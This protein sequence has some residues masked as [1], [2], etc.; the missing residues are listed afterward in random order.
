LSFTK[1]ELDG[2]CS[3]KHNK[4]VPK[5]FKIELFF[6]PTEEIKKP[7]VVEDL[8][9]S[10]NTITDLPTVPL[11]ATNN[12]NNNN[13]NNSNS[14][15]KKPAVSPETVLTPRTLARSVGHMASQPSTVAD[16][17]EEVVQVAKKKYEN[18]E[19]VV[20]GNYDNSSDVDDD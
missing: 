15:N 18:A 10:N 20:D 9:K 14:N 4:I 19:K 6:C 8:K 17:E 11:L 2:L 12:N 5:N 1:E 16:D 13:D 3:D 7:I